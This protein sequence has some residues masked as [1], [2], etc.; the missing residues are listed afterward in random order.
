M[1]PFHLH[2]ASVSVAHNQRF[3]NVAMA[4]DGC[5]PT[6]YVILT[7]QF[8]P[9]EQD[10]RLG[11]TGVYLEIDDQVRATYRAAISCTLEQ[12]KLRIRVDPGAY[13]RLRIRGDVVIEIA[14]AAID[15]EKLDAALVAI[16][17]SGPS[18]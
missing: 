3:A 6:S 17:K 7:R 4:D 5:A 14:D 16:F 9:D 2:A 11:L 15:L 10:V 12:R 18:P 1:E 8:D 13:G